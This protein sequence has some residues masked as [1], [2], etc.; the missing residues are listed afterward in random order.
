MNLLNI[1]LLKYRTIEPATSV[2]RNH[3]TLEPVK[4]SCGLKVF[5][6]FLLVKYQLTVAVLKNTHGFVANDRNYSTTE[7]VKARGATFNCSTLTGLLL[8]FNCPTL[9]A[10][11]LTFNC[12]TLTAEL[13]TFY[14]QTLTA[15]LLTFNFQTLTAV[16]LTFIRPSSET[17]PLTALPDDERPPYLS[18][19]RWTPRGHGL[20]TVLDYDIYFRPA[21]RSSTGYRVTA[22]AV[23][24]VVYNGVPDWLY[25]G[26]TV[27]F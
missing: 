16:L 26:N 21:P 2:Y 11:L 23:P 15:M 13:L 3:S 14:Y 9:T 7:P 22:T 8:T 20:V 6:C 17:F 1:L 25:E 18:L 4:H 5:C 12:Q 19:A 27:I 10:V 24:G